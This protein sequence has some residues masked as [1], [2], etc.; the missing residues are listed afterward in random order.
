MVS[1]FLDEFEKLASWSA[2]QLNYLRMKFKV[3]DSAFKEMLGRVSTGKSVALLTDKERAAVARLI[4]AKYIKL[5]PLKLN[6]GKPVSSDI[7]RSADRKKL[8]IGVKREKGALNLDLMKRIVKK[9]R[10]STRPF[11]SI[12]KQQRGVR[13]GLV[14]GNRAKARKGYKSR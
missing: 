14:R 11:K 10:L 2:D 1:Y 9:N 13:L 12:R 5:K 6:S 3:P 8:L 7:S 4:V